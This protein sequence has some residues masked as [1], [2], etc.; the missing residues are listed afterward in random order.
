MNLKIVGAREFA[1]RKSFFERA[2]VAETGSDVSPFRDKRFV[3][4]AAGDIAANGHRAESAAVIALAAG[5]NAVTIFF[6][7]FE[8]KLAREFYGGLFW[9]IAA[10]RRVKPGCAPA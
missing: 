10:R 5:K 2:V 8:V 9:L 1:L 3:G 7:G 4:R 6:A